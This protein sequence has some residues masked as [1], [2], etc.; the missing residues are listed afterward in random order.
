[1]AVGWIGFHVTDRC[2]LDCKHCL[3]DPEQK[4]KDIDVGL[5]GRTLDEAR[6]IYRAHHTMF[7]GGEPTL[8]PDFAGL[9]DAAAD[10]GFTW[11]MVSN[12]RKFPHVM[13]MLKARP[14]RRQQCASISFSL[15]GADEAVHDHIRGAGSFREVM[16][17]VSVCEVNDLKFVLQ[18]AVHAKNHHQIEAMGML[19]S[20]LGAGRLSFVM[21]QPT[22]SLHDADLFLSSRQWRSV[23]ERID[24]L[25]SVVRVPISRPEGF[26]ED[27]PFH[28]CLPWAGQQFHI[29]VEGR[30]NLC[31][32]HSGIPATNP[33]SDVAGDLNAMSLVDAHGKLIDI[34]HR[35]QRAKVAR[36]AAKPATE[37][38]HF[39]CND[40]MKSFGK[41]H[42]TE[43][44]AAGP[45]AK[46]ERWRGAW[47]PKS[48]PIVR[49]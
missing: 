16:T 1:M 33:G 8:H 2:Q 44:A 23:M 38:D 29:D 31:C 18:M 25:Q 14:I 24:R 43:Q 26:Y 3:R 37:W 40:C 10:R 36:L 11:H 45:S 46:R 49:G 13:D 9:V 22:G 5:V 41:P 17:A 27:E 20:Q 34:I 4:P 42:W 30:L 48:L 39:P 19:A 32:Q 47:A 12:G 6:R 7:T 28:V 15:D 21:T 35:E